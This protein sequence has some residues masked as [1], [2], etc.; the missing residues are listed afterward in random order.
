VN[1]VVRSA[2]ALILCGSCLLPAGATDGNPPK[3][4]PSPTPATVTLS[5]EDV[6]RARDILEAGFVEDPGDEKSAWDTLRRRLDSYPEWLSSDRSPAQTALKLS[7]QEEEAYACLKHALFFSY[8]PVG[9]L[10]LPA[11]E[12]HAVALL[13]RSPAAA[14]A[15]R[16]LLTEATLAGQLHALSGLERVDRAGFEQ[17][18]AS[19]LLLSDPRDSRQVVLRQR[20]C[21]VEVS[22][23]A[24]VARQV[25]VGRYDPAFTPAQRLAL[26]AKFRPLKQPGP[27]GQQP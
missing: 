12:P 27:S 2:A 15:F 26:A 20:G 13:A 10:R 14:G 22:V 18:V 5:D 11:P 6:L 25:F 24:T 9:F 4:P 7:L 3:S 1:G 17:A 21:L 19:Y 8:G 23:A 16:L